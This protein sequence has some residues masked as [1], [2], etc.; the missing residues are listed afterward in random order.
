MLNATI[1]AKCKEVYSQFFDS[2]FNEATKGPGSFVRPHVGS[3]YKLGSLTGLVIYLAPYDM[4][5][6]TIQ[7][8]GGRDIV[9][10]YSFFEIAG[11]TKVVANMIN[12]PSTEEGDRII[13]AV[14]ASLA[15]FKRHFGGLKEEAEPERRAPARKAPRAARSAA[16]GAHGPVAKAAPAAR[17]AKAAVSPRKAAVQAK[18]AK[19][20]KRVMPASA[21]SPAKPAPAAR[22]AKAAAASPRKAAA[23]AKAAKPTPA[24]K[25]AAFG[26]P[27]RSVA[28]S[29]SAPKKK[30]SARPA[31]SARSMAPRAS[32]PRSSTRA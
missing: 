15:D 11:G 2:S 16:S 6:M 17:S 10:A 26:K 4:V 30:A 32:R 3:L 20:A 14:E 12:V 28:S 9:A 8:K 18:A 21:A 27:A 5:V 24:V 1:A 7:I 13:E 22:P 19:P 25:A 23:P 29:V 31:A